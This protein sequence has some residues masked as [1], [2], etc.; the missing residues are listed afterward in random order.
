MPCS[1]ARPWLRET[2]LECEA[3]PPDF[4]GSARL[5]DDPAAIGREMRRV[6][7]REDRRASSVR[8][9]QEAIGALRTAIEDIV[10]NGWEW[11]SHGEIY[12]RLRCSDYRQEPL[13]RI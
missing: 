7:G 1:S 6:L 8:S 9:W 11:I 13:L 12:H 4:V 10:N 5:T 3:E 2:L